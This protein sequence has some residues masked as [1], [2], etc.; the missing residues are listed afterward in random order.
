MSR[1]QLHWTVVSARVALGVIAAFILGTEHPHGM[2]DTGFFL[3]VV[4]IFGTAHAAITSFLVWKWGTTSTRVL[5]MH[6]AVLFGAPT[7][8]GIIASIV[9]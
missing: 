1:W 2:F 7:L 5:L 8:F 3:I 9:S 6:G 4:A